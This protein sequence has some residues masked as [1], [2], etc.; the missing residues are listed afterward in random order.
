MVGWLV[1]Y[2]ALYIL[3]FLLNTRRIIQTYIWNPPKQVVILYISVLLPAAKNKSVPARCPAPNFAAGRCPQLDALAGKLAASTEVRWNPAGL[4]GAAL[5]LPRLLPSCHTSYRRSEWVDLPHVS[6]MQSA[7][8]SWPTTS[9]A[10]GTRAAAAVCGCLP[11]YYSR[12]LC[13]FGG[14]PC[15]F[16]YPS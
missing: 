1:M 15:W 7:D 8:D 14:I 9:S 4:A 5:S 2:V 12:I 13:R 3:V 10:E 11:A 16:Y 6:Q